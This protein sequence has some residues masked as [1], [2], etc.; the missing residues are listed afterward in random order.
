MMINRLF[1]LLLRRGTAKS[2]EQKSRYSLREVG[3]M[4]DKT[5][6]VDQSIL[7]DIQDAFGDKHTLRVDEVQEFLQILKPETVRKMIK[8]GEL[9][10]ISVGG[11]WR[12]TRSSFE[13]YCQRN[14]NLNQT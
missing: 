5:L 3:C 4:S 10:A 13:E 9:S 7:K 1:R 12:I 2:R 11:Y 8:E 6:W 14:S